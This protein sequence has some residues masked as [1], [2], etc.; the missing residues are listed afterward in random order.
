MNAKSIK[1]FLFP[2]LL[3]MTSPLVAQQ[4]P[5]A[6]SPFEAPGAAEPDRRIAAP[7]GSVAGDDMGDHIADRVLNMNGFNITNLEDPFFEGDAVTLGYFNAHNGWSHSADQDI[8]MGGFGLLNIGRLDLD[9]A[10]LSGGRYE[11]SDITTA[12]IGDSTM[13]NSIITRATI[14]GSK[15]T[16]PRLS[17][18]ILS[19]MTRI[20]G[21]V[22][23]TGN[24]LTGLADATAET[25]AMTMRATRAMIDEKIAGGAASADMDEVL[26]R[27]SD[28][29]KAVPAAGTVE[30]ISGQVEAMAARVPEAGAIE[31][32]M[33]QVD[34]LEKRL[35]DAATS[36]AVAA[37]ETALGDIEARLATGLP[38]D[39]ETSR[40]RPTPELADALGRLTGEDALRAISAID[41]MVYNLPDDGGVAVGIAP[42]SIPPEL[43]F[44]VRK[45]GEG[46]S[47]T[48]RGVDYAQMIGPMVAAIRTLS[49][50]VEILEDDRVFRD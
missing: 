29:E 40:F 31:A 33:D 43:R 25:D 38:R 14:D 16:E 1:Y 48:A 35:G 32:V 9:D 12:M 8:D 45:Y 15:L 20:E 22:D 34:T 4:V 50:R 42:G 3:G 26:A 24:A 49:E 10:T 28:L 23:M 47:Y 19:G 11:E 36:E 30:E 2:A 39:A 5:E 44:L 46:D 18:A 13:T 7:R 41:A 37:L 27:I 17:G 21:G 6:P